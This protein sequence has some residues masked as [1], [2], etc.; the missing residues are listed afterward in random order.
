MWTL[1]KM[2]SDWSVASNQRMSDLNVLDDFL[3]KAYES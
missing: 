1:K 2:N 3:L